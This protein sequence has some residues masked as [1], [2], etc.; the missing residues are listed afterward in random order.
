MARRTFRGVRKSKNYIW[1]AVR[2]NLQPDPGI[3]PLKADIVS[4]PQWRASATGF[5]HATLVSVRGWV[6][7]TNT[8]TPTDEQRSTCAIIKT[9]EEE[10]TD[11]PSLVVM[12][13]NTDILWTGGAVFGTG[14]VGVGIVYHDI[15]VKVSRKIN[16]DEEIRFVCNNEGLATSD[17]IFFGVLRGLVQ[18]TS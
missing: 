13:E 9:G 4:P 3:S 17:P 15:N 10:P 12:Y 1:T 5:Q 14:Q 7:I 18:T 6:A 16:T 8:E 11:D 2:V